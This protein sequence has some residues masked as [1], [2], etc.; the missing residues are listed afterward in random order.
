MS[1]R[2]LQVTVDVVEH[3]AEEALQRAESPPPDCGW[4][5]PGMWP[6]PSK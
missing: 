3:E 4:T 5:V 2:D 1:W 6:P